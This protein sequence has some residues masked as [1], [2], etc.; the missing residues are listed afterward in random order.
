MP[1]PISRWLDVRSKKDEIDV[2]DKEEERPFPVA[3]FHNAHKTRWL[4]LRR[5]QAEE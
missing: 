1:L 2:I 3:L 4:A 5:N